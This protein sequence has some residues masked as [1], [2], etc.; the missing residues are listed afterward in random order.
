M[1]EG[2]LS[3]EYVE[4]LSPISLRQHYGEMIRMRASRRREELH[5]QVAAAVA[6]SDQGK[7]A[8]DMDSALSVVSHPTTVRGNTPASDPSA[9]KSLDDLAGIQ[10]RNAETAHLWRD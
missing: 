4:S 9:N 3:P 1:A 8:K 2:G 10:R 5:V 6:T 7:A